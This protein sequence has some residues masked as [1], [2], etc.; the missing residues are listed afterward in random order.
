MHRFFVNI[1][2]FDDD[3]VVLS[4]DQAHQLLKVLRM[5]VG[6]RIIVLDDRGWEYVLELDRIERR[7]ASGKII[8][9]RPA[10]AE[11]DLQI[12]VYQGLMKGDR[13]SWVLQKCTEIG[14]RRLVPVI[15][16][17]T[18]IQ[19][20]SRVG[21]NRL[22]RWRRIIVEAAEQS[23]RG[24]IP[25]LGP[26]MSFAHALEEI[27]AG[28]LSLIPWEMASEPNLRTVLQSATPSRCALFIGPEGG[29]ERDEL[30]QAREKGVIPITLGP[31]ILRTETAAVVASALLLYESGALG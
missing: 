16:R 8:E 3:T 7:H 18:S 24:R 15:T 6:A 27:E 21:P 5:K 20:P 23:K 31:R 17:R 28:Q 2:S 22:A 25:A 19:D 14:V 4:A 26:V 10:A 13:F 30:A 1:D 9:K 12:T 11:P 29:F